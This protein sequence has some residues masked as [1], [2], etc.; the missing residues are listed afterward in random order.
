MALPIVKIRGVSKSFGS[1]QVLS[2]IDLDINEGEIFGLIGASGAGKTTLLEAMVGFIPVSKGEIAYR[3]DG[4]VMNFVSIKN[5]SSPKARIGFSTQTPSFY[6]KLTVNENLEYFA[7]L[8]DIPEQFIKPRTAKILE[9]VELTG[10]ENTVA[11]ELSGGMQKRLDIA[12][13][14]VNDPQILIL[15]EPTADLDPLLRKHIWALIKKINSFGKTVII[16]SHFL[17]EMDELCSRIA[18]I[19]NKSIT[20][21]GTTEEFRKKFPYNQE[22]ILNLASQRYE[23]LA[24]MLKG[25]PISKMIVRGNKTVIYTQQT[26]TVLKRVLD[27]VEQQRETILDLDVQKPTLDEV[28]TS[29]VNNPGAE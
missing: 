12:C 20:H 29:I 7:K 16:S 19:Y 4:A 24:S 17:E 6:D 23:Q 3:K 26:E 8:Y 28:F 9:L 15:D 22:I 27:I 2:D 11:A 14:L 25:L 18:L 1:K 5:D 21:L 13:A 10:E